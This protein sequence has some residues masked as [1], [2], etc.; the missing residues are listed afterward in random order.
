MGCNIEVDG[1]GSTINSVKGYTGNRGLEYAKTE[2]VNPE[3]ILTTLVKIDGV[4]NDL[5]PVR[6]N[7]RVPKDK[8]LLI[9]EEIKKISVKLPIKMHQVIIENVCNTGA[10]IVATKELK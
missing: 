5:L 8:V 6:S 1:E 3:R 4:E 7:K 10:D 2:F 9:V